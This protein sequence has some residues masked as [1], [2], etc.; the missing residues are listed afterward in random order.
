MGWNFSFFFF[1]RAPTFFCIAAAVAAAIL[2][3]TK[4]DTNICLCSLW[5]QHENYFYIAEICHFLSFFSSLSLVL[6]IILYFSLPLSHTHIMQ[7]MSFCPFPLIFFH[8]IC[9]FLFSLKKMSSSQSSKWSEI[10]N[11]ICVCI[12]T[13]FILV[14]SHSFFLRNTYI[15]Q[16]QRSQLWI[17]HYYYCCYYFYCDGVRASWSKKWKKKLLFQF[18]FL[19]ILQKYLIF[20]GFS[21]KIMTF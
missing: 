19:M 21:L 4:I 10:I 5:T 1:L 15:P 18:V 13:Y 20:C 9:D 7:R 2:P 16:N 11:R 14:Q 12:S 3:G 17:I 8:F 6:S